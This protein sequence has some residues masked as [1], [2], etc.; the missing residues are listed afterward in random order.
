MKWTDIMRFAPVSDTDTDKVQK[1]AES[2]R[3]NGWQGAPI[4]VSETCGRLITGSHRYAALRLIEE[5]TWANLDQLGDIAEPIDDIINAWCEENDAVIDQLP[6][7]NL[8][9]VFAGTWVEEYKSEIAE[10]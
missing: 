2:I 10:W 3:S 9:E 5:E 8:R 1:I 4:L 7:D 6:Y